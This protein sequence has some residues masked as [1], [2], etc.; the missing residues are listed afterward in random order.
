MRDV[1]IRGENHRVPPNTIHNTWP[2]I[3]IISRY[4]DSAIIYRLLDN[5]ITIHHDIPY[6]QRRIQTDYEKVWCW[7]LVVQTELVY[8]FS[9]HTK[10]D[11]DCYIQVM[12]IFCAI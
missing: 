10:K 8:R 12:D 2:T 4:R 5:P 7:I 9:Y 6:V 11:D 1:A 3:P